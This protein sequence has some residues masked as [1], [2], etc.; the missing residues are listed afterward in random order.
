MIYPNSVQVNS[1]PIK[2]KPKEKT[3]PKPEKVRQSSL[4]TQFVLTFLN[5][6]ICYPLQYI[7]SEVIILI[8][9]I[10]KKFPAFSGTEKR[11][12]YIYI[13]NEYYTNPGKRYPVLYM[14]DGHNAFFDKDATYGKSWGIGKYLKRNRIPLIVVGVDCNHGEHD[15]RVQEYSPYDFEYTAGD[16]T[17]EAQLFKGYGNDTLEWFTKVLKPQ[18]DSSYRTI[19]GREGTFVM[20]SSM[21]GLMSLHA[22]LRYNHVFSKACALSPAMELW[23]DSILTEINRYDYFADTELYIDYGMLEEDFEGCY[24]ALVE[25]NARLAER[26]ISITFR[27]V[28]NGDHNE[29]SWERQLPFAIS[30]LM[31]NK[32]AIE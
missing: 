17:G 32:A 18:I 8:K 28:P 29:A 21:G 20:G 16:G 25:I 3:V 14:F 13:P 10:T 19:A 11:K 30:T 12:V 22:L 31:Y 4:F 24:D 9:I 15:E 5:I 1:M 27:T 23:Y 6:V 26:N 7:C 2:L